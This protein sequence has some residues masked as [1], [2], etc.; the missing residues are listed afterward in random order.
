VS[1]DAKKSLPSG[2][3]RARIGEL[4]GADGVFIDG[5]W[6]ESKDQ[7]PDGDVRLIQLADV[8]GGT[9][10]NR[11]SRFLT[12]KKAVELRCTFLEQGDVLIARMP[13]PLGRACI[14][15]GD[16]KRAVTVV[17]V[18]IVRTGRMGAN[19]RWL[20]WAINSPDFRSAVAGLQS[21]STRKRISRGN[22]ATLFLP[23]P[24]LPEEARIADEIEKQF[25]RLDAAVAA[26]KRIQVNLN[27]YR[28]AVLK[29]ACEGRLVPT[30]A[31]LA[32]R[33]DRSY[34]P[35]SILLERILAERRAAWEADQI[36]KLG[37][38]GKPPRDEKWR[39][40]YKLPDTP[41]KQPNCEVPEGWV[42][43]N[44]GQLSWSVK[45]GPHYSPKYVEE[46]IPFV[47]GGQ[48]RPSGV[49]FASAKRIS[50]KLHSELLK[51]CKPEPGDILYTKGGTTGIARVNTYNFEFSVWV[52]VAV[53]KLVDSSEPFYIQHALNSPQCYAQARIFTHG[54]G[55]QDLGLT[56]MVRI[57]FLLPPVA[58]QKRVVA[59][60]DRRLSVIDEI[61][62]QLAGDLQRAERLRQMILKRA[63]E[64]KLVEQN[65]EDES[66]SSL[67]EKIRVERAQ[68]S[69]SIRARKPSS[70]RRSEQGVAG[71]AG[72]TRG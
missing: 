13:D 47:T 50:P 55:N 16:S 53:L 52:H 63:F 5:D 48:V 8:G 34:E 4:V 59:E 40:K 70:V 22:L 61:E 11:S 67:L 28:S 35:A 26:L 17:D 57:A 33:E 2:W 51:R 43:V 60:V 65:S 39:A 19:H 46:G 42:L 3:D 12:S 44:L 7:D 68:S 54:V 24:P 23:I 69:V 37:A 66:A 64:G 21:G 1:F 14:F 27:R 31:E 72:A 15:P 56:R 41:D 62:T 30:E 36:N 29:A 9:Y 49:D 6:V 10:Q 58:E 45:D 18:C 25:T 20:T 38:S 71:S 32:R